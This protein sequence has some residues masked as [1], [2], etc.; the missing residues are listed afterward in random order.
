MWKV[1]APRSRIV[2]Q[3]GGGIGPRLS[4]AGAR[5][6]CSVDGSMSAK[7]LNVFPCQ[8]VAPGAA[9]SLKIAAYPESTHAVTA[10]VRGHPL[11][12][13]RLRHSA[14]IYVQMAS[15]PKSPERDWAGHA[16]SQTVN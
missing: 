1:H 11:P 15:G 12:R 2:L 5:S 6:F 16:H 9:A 13:V 14:Q 8:S 3:Q 10:H 7:L 4:V